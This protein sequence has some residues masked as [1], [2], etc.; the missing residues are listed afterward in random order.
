M[1]TTTIFV[2]ELQNN[3]ASVKLHVSQYTDSR[4]LIQLQLG[5]AFHVECFLRYSILPPERLKLVETKHVLCTIGNRDVACQT[6]W[7]MDVWCQDRKP[8]LAGEL[9]TFRD[10]L[11][12]SGVADNINVW[13]LKGVLI[14]HS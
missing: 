10:H 2:L 14:A 6:R 1:P 8:E 12:S 13:E 9:M 7:E 3:H 4:V 11:L 5:D